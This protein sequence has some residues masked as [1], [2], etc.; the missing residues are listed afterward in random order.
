MI[1][2]TLANDPQRDEG[3]RRP[4][5]TITPRLRDGSFSKLACFSKTYS[6]GNPLHLLG[7]IAAGDLGRYPK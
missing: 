5:T 7:A 2:K 3:R 4:K 1:S 6:A